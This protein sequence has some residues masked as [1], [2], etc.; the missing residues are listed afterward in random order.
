MVTKLYENI[1]YKKYDITITKSGTTV[2]DSAGNFIQ[3]FPT[4]QAAANA[5][6]R[7]HAAIRTA[8]LRNGTSGGYKWKKKSQ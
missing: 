2:R 3:E 5:V 1:Q 7:T 4:I 6:G 8:I